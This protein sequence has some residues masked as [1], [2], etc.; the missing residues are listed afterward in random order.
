MR[1]PPQLVDR[2]TAGNILRSQFH[3]RNP[4]ADVDRLSLPRYLTLLRWPQS[5]LFPPQNPPIYWPRQ[6]EAFIARR[7]P[8]DDED[9]IQ[10]RSLW[11]VLRY[12]P[13]PS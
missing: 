11:I 12:G 2:K 1:C 7:W 13:E 4:L 9:P 10:A 6:L 8:L 5:T 3:L